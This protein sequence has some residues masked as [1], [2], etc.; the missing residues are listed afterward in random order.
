MSD[1]K[2]EFSAFIK[3]TLS[4]VRTDYIRKLS[5]NKLNSAILENILSENEAVYSDTYNFIDNAYVESLLSVLNPSEEQII[6]L[7]IIDGYSE[8]ETA[9]VMKISRSAVKQKLYRAKQ[10]LKILMEEKKR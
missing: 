10:K 7:R 6:R 1:I 4:N 9:S 8:K 5:N 2:H 3:K